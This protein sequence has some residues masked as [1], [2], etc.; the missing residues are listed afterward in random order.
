[1]DLSHFVNNVKTVENSGTFWGFQPSYYLKGVRKMINHTIETAH[2]KITEIRLSIMED[3]KKLFAEHG[4]SSTDIDYIICHT[5][6]GRKQKEALIFVDDMRRNKMKI[7]WEHT[8]VWSV[9]SKN[10]HFFDLKV[11]NGSIT[12]VRIHEHIRFIKNYAIHCADS[13]NRLI[14]TLEKLISGRRKVYQGT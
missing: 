11:D 1:M 13:M 9:K 8:N 2:E 14:G 4:V 6:E 10:K 12:I 5:L 7:K 3:A